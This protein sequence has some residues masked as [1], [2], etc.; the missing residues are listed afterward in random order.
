MTCIKKNVLFGSQRY[1]CCRTSSSSAKRYSE[2]IAG[3]SV[4]IRTNDDID[5]CAICFGRVAQFAI[6]IQVFVKRALGCKSG[7]ERSID[8]VEAE[9]FW[10]EKVRLAR[11][12][13][14]ITNSS[15]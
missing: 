14:E 8:T 13:I 15:R 5:L 6:L 4:S 10:R 7:L 11:S 3:Y 12:I 2:C 9:S 1:I